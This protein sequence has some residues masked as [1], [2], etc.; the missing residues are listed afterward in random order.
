MDKV[1]K[2]LIVDDEAGVRE[3]LADYLEDLG[4]TVFTAENGEKALDVLADHPM[5]LAIVDVR[6]PGID[7]T[8]TIVKARNIQPDLRYIVHTGSVTYQIAPELKAMGITSE[9]ILHKPVSNLET[10]IQ[11]IR[12]VMH[13]STE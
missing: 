2:I 11:T 12:R 13:V 9:Q 5:D 6:L 1:L 7:G 3:S 4:F 8:Q 10:I